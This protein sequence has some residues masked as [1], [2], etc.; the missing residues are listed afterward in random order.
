MQRMTKIAWR[1]APLT[2]ALGMTAAVVLAGCGTTESPADSLMLRHAGAAASS[3]ASSNAR[4]ART[5]P[6]E[7]L[8][9]I[10]LTAT[11]SEAA[12]SHDDRNARA[13]VSTRGGV[14]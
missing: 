7:K 14:R 11:P 10:L 5:R 8:R 12:R 6:L 3:N 9:P 2:L 13:A 4:A 1:K